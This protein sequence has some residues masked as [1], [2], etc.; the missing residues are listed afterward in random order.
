MI[1]LICFL[2]SAFFLDRASKKINKNSGKFFFVVSVLIPVLLATIRSSEV[3][4]DVKVYVQPYI[5][6][7]LNDNSLIS[8]FS[9]MIENG[10]EIGYI[11]LN[12]VG[13]IYLGGLSG[14]FFL[15]MLLVILPVYVRI[16]DYKEEIPVWIVTLIFLLI[17]YNLSLNLA[18]QAIALS[19]V[20]YAFKYIEHNKLKMFYLF[21]I[22]AF[23][24]HNSALLGFIYVILLKISS[25]KNWRLKQLLILFLLFI[26]IIFYDKIFALM[27]SIFFSNNIEKYL[28]AFLS[29]ETGY[30]SFWM[31]G[32]NIFTIICVIFSKTYLMKISYYK[33]FLLI[34]IFNFFLYLLTIY[35]G[36]CFRYSLY[37]TIM[38]PRIVPTVRYRFKQD[39]RILVDILITI[40]FIWYWINFNMISDSYGTIPYLIH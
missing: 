40:I 3:G 39:S 8:Y 29:D 16:L 21:I 31:V 18:R 22:I 19:I 35:N 30:L 6:L 11:L 25:G 20:F 14:V 9:T 7:A 32:I 5:Q 12:Y 15:S 28:N 33:Y 24:F 34:V 2:L 37:F 10:I 26:F 13:A 23:L 38:L 4:I 36:N 17:F 1:Y 27:V